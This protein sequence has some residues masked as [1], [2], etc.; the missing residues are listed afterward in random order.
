MKRPPGAAADGGEEPLGRRLLVA[1]EAV[2][3]GLDLF[4][5]RPR[6]IEVR[7]R[8]LGADAGEERLVLV[9]RRPGPLVEDEVRAGARGPA[10]SSSS[11]SSISSDGFPAQAWRRKIASMWRAAATIFPS[12]CRSFAGSGGEVGGDHR[13][14]EARRHRARGARARPTAGPAPGAARA[15]RARSGK[16]RGRRPRAG[17]PTRGRRRVISW[18]KRLHVDDTRRP[19]A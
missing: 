12:A 7:R 2:H 19:R 10:A 14:G 9:Q 3:P 4:L 5:G 11:T 18:R 1:A 17:R 16:R 13:G 15:P 8:R 6:G